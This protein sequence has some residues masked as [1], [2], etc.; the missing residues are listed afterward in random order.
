VVTLLRGSPACTA[1]VTGRRTG[2]LVV[3]S[4][5]TCL[6][7]AEITGPVSVRP[8][9]SLVASASSI[10]GPLSASGASAVELL[11]SSVTGSVTISG[12]AEDVTVVGGRFVG[13][14]HLSNNRTGS[15]APILAGA[16]V[17]G[18]I[19]CNS[20]EP[21]PENLQALNTVHGPAS[22]QCTNL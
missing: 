6:D 10:V 19:S 9:A 4:G 17:T 16:T 5:V 2:P 3:S 15:R 13:P 7:H 11:N 1:T 21:A 20:N 18:L 8:G 22:G 12:T 14:V